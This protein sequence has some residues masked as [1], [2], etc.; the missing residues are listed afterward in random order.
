M[1]CS[2]FRGYGE[3]GTDVYSADDEPARPL[4]EY[5]SSRGPSRSH[6]SCGRKLS[7]SPPRDRKVCGSTAST[8]SRKSNQMISSKSRLHSLHMEV[9][10]PSFHSSSTRKRKQSATCLKEREFS[11]DGKHR[12][13]LPH[14]RT[15]RHG[16][17]CSHHH[18]SRKLSAYLAQ[19][20]NISPFYLRHPPYP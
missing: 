20:A 18:H 9:N 12:S 15:S 11:P 16:Q 4:R 17:S 13:L 7:R 3:P 1:T 14:S 19:E 8:R 6:K 2:R 10:T 5:S